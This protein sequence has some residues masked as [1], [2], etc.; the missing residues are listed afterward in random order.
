M[1]DIKNFLSKNKTNA[2]GQK[3]PWDDV[4]ILF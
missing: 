4:I 2:A 3:K 1:I